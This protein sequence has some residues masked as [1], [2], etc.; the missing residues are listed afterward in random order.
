M[1]TP[2][3]ELG[4]FANNDAIY[5]VEFLDR[6]KDASDLAVPKYVVKKVKLTV[7]AKKAT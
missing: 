2:I 4:I 5:R 7:L 3:G 1:P 6:V